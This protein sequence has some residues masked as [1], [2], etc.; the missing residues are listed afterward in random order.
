[1]III[2]DP[3]GTT[4]DILKKWADGKYAKASLHDILQPVFYDWEN[5]EFYCIPE[6]VDYWFEYIWRYNNN[7]PSWKKI[8]E[9]C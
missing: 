9:Q 1:M 2:N 4:S 8:Y 3:E 5:K 7:L 6:E